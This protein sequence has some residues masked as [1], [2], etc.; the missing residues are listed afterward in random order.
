MAFSRETKEKSKQL[1]HIPNILNNKTK[2]V[3][4]KMTKSINPPK[5]QMLPTCDI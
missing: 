3:N 1:M 5:Y 4:K 2:S